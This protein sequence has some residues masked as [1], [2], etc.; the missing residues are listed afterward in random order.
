MF[1]PSQP[2]TRLET[3]LV[4]ARLEP[5]TT[6][7]SISHSSCWTR[8]QISGSALVPQIEGVC[9]R[10]KPPVRLQ[11]L[12]SLGPAG[13]MLSSAFHCVT[14]CKSFLHSD[15]PWWVSAVVDHWDYS[16]GNYTCQV[17]RSMY[18]ES[19]W[20]SGFKVWWKTKA[21]Q[22]GKPQQP[23]SLE[24]LWV[25]IGRCHWHFRDFAISA[26]ITEIVKVLNGHKRIH[27]SF[28]HSRNEM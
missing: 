20:I 7:Q 26:L 16:G 28:V 11:S 14:Q 5:V 17:W 12:C 22:V 10:V 25:L 2:W 3:V 9:R 8:T 27:R 1:N 19:R 6:S 4:A 24:A 13:V 18:G 15:L 23:P 21:T